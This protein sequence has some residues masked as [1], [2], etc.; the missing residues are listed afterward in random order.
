MVAAA[1]GTDAV[2]RAE[3]ES[4]AFFTGGLDGAH[5]WAFDEEVAARIVRPVLLV[6]GGA[7]P[8]P[9]HRLVA[10]LEGLLP[11]ATV[12]TVADEDHLLPLRSPGALGELIAALARR[13]QVVGFR[14]PLWS[15]HTVHD[16]RTCC[17]G[18]AGRTRCVPAQGRISYTRLNGLSAARRNRVKPASAAISRTAAS[19]DCAPSA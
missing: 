14:D 9:V 5:G 15:S 19:P 12:S 1:L 13:H 8:P 7:T 3:R 18:C 17:A 11:D 4:R 2:E 10:R 6:Q 16:R